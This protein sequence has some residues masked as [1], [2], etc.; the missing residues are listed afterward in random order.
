MGAKGDWD[1]KTI[2]VIVRGG[3]GD[4]YEDPLGPWDPLDPNDPRNM[5]IPSWIKFI[6]EQWSKGLIGDAEF[7]NAIRFL[8]NAN[9]IVI[10]DLPEAGQ[11]DR[12]DIPQWIKFNAEQ[13][14]NGA[15]SDSEFVSG[16]KWIIEN[17]IIQLK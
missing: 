17:G 13:W 10:P 16:I 9:V 15:L 8:V 4:D 3:G 6:A 5:R 12:D 14:V 11:A 2:K 7:A 1:I